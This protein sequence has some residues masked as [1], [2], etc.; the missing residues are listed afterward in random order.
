MPVSSEALVAATARAERSLR[1]GVLRDATG[2]SDVSVLELPSSPGSSANPLSLAHYCATAGE[3]MRVAQSGSDRRARNYLIS[4]LRHAESAGATDLSARIAYR[5]A[6]V[7][8]QSTA[9]PNTRSA[10]R[11]VRAAMDDKAE[12]PA[13]PLGV[14]AACGILFQDT[15]NDEPSWYA[16]QYSLNCAAAH[17]R[18]VGD[19]EIGALAQLQIARTTIAEAERRPFSREELR[20]EAAKAALAGLG[21]VQAMTPGVLRTEL[22]ARLIEAGLDAQL[23]EQ[24]EIRSSLT[25]LRET[26]GD[27]PGQRA[28]LL[29][30]EGRVMA[31]AGRNADAAAALRRAIFFE[32]QRAQ[33]L[34]LGDWY[35]LLARAEPAQRDAHILQAYRA[36]ESV[37]PL[38]P[39]VDPITEESSFALRMQPVFRAA[40]ESQLDAAAA[41]KAGRI[42]IAQ[43]IVEDF[44]QAEIQSTFGRDCVPAREPIRPDQLVAGEVLLYPILLDDRVELLIASAG[45]PDYRRLTPA[46]SATRDRVSALVREMTY[47]LGYSIGERWEK[48]ARELYEIL[49]A[50]VEDKLGPGT[51]LV[52][53][54]DGLLRM[55]PFASLRDREGKFLIERTRLSIAPALAYAQPGV[56][57]RGSPG[58]V[59]ASLEES[60]EFPAGFFPALAGTSA[61]AKAA[62]GLDAANGRHGIFLENFRRADLERAFSGR[63]IDI[64]H[65]AT[66]A[67]F[68]G[69]SERSFIVTKDGPLLLSELRALIEANRSRGEELALIVLSACETAVG[70]DQ[71][72][73][74]LA[75]TAVQAGA[76][77]AVASLWQVDDA[78]TAELMRQFYGFIRQ[79]Q[80]K[81]EAL[82]NAQLALMA[83][84]EELG[85]PRIWAAFT[86]LGG[87]R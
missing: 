15:F 35:L 28:V 75:G 84:G 4:A 86:L 81:A 56:H 37:R 71:A 11:T 26:T 51:T 68:N 6:L 32:S 1:S 45:S 7:V 64:L 63:Q 17:S 61:E 25:L 44:R 87:W 49:I 65:L 31:A 22:L 67:A 16:A 19:R 66:H 21:D 55:L 77:S 13:P 57:I 14:D 10:R 82:R 41:G 3:I 47:S 46:K 9:N 80:G 40:V 73:M 39:Q 76:Q 38:L 33:P 8:G 42:R 78:G 27:D 50:P 70:D 58:I 5:L 12:R 69:R 72:S 34:R 85:D 18:Q 59:A 79:G 62:A 52:I 30:L 20:A 2:G 29:A 24:R 83:K 54:P 60:V 48:P 53:V 43:Q 74:G 23:G 36:L